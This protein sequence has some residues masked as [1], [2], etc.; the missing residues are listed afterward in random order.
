MTERPVRQRVLIAEDDMLIAIMIEE[1]V[2]GAGYTPVGPFSTVKDA[3]AAIEHDGLPDG[4]VLDMQLG[5]ERAYLIADV[6]DAG[7]VPFLLMTGQAAASLPE[8][9]QQR[10]LVAKPCTP[11]DVLEALARALRPGAGA[12]RRAG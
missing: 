4:A 1:A 2:R 7:G 8:R 5:R 12:E 3:L 10:P 6:L 11:E 9:L